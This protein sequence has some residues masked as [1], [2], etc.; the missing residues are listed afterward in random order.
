VKRARIIFLIIFILLITAYIGGC[1]RAGLWLAKDDLPEHADA[2]VLLMGDFPGRV[3]QAA[4]LFHEGRAEKLVIVHESMGAY[5]LLE[6]R[7]VNIVT[8]TEQAHNAFL[9]LGVPAS[10]VTVL[11]YDARSTLD[12]AK[13]TRDFL[14]QASNIDTI[15]LVSAPYHLR[16]ASM[17]FNK[18]IRKSGFKVYVGSSPS[19]YTSYNP[20]EWWKRK[21][22]IQAVLSEYLKLISFILIEHRKV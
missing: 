1:R 22:D 9:V 19:K 3:L 20:R 7:G 18:A 4:D 15:I 12:E 8:S 11:P 6:S 14:L 2:M 16:R 21:E 17:I 13:A 10:V 5:K